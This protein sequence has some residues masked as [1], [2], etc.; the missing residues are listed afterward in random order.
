MKT[1]PTVTSPFV[2]YQSGGGLDLNTLK[3]DGCRDMVARELSRC[4]ALWGQLPGVREDEVRSDTRVSSNAFA[5]RPCY[6]KVMLDVD[7]NDADK[8]AILARLRE[9]TTAAARNLPRLLAAQSPGTTGRTSR[10]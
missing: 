6:P 3:R 9:A 5:G 10:R 2:T 4:R 8:K 1:G 7:P